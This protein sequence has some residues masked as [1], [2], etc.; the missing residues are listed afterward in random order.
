ME[1]R[2]LLNRFSRLTPAGKSGKTK[3][4]KNEAGEWCIGNDCFRLTAGAEQ[5]RISF[6]PNPKA[7]CPKDIDSALNQLRRLAK[8]GK[9]TRLSL[10]MAEDEDWE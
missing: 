1:K 8:A 5:L 10:P 7:N 6:N 2:T 9:G 3:A 4:Y